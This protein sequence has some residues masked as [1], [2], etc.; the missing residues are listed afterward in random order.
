MGG[1][2][3]NVSVMLYVFDVFYF[4]FFPPT[5]F[6]FL[7]F[8]YLR[9]CVCTS[10]VCTQSSQSLRTPLTRR[11]SSV[12]SSNHDRRRRRQGPRLGF[13]S[14]YNNYYFYYYADCTTLFAAFV[15]TLIPFSYSSSTADRSVIHSRYH[16]LT[17]PLTIINFFNTSHTNRMAQCKLALKHFNEPARLVTVYLLK[18]MF[19]HVHDTKFN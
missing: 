14:F 11:R 5:S 7:S 16:L 2:Y 3:V 4:S 17:H 13:I 9:T 15:F 10:N 1:A 12:T 6:F 8:Y 19:F 18:N